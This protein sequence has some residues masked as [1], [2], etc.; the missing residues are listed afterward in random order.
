M[1]EAAE[2][3]SEDIVFSFS[4]EIVDKIYGDPSMT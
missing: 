3:E 2:F 1:V 4:G